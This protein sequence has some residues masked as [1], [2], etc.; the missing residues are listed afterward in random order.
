M[1]PN[2]V[3]LVL[4][5][6]LFVGTSDALACIGFIGA[7]N[8]VFDAKDKSSKEQELAKQIYDHMVKVDD[9]IP[10]LS[11][12]EKKWLESEMNAKDSRRSLRAL[13]SNEA[14]LK[15]AKEGVAV[16][17]FLSKKILDGNYKH[18]Q[19]EVESWANIAGTLLDNRI[20]EALFILHQREVIKLPE[21]AGVERL[22]QPSCALVARNI[23]YSI[24]I[25]YL[26]EE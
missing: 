7:A 12:V 15:Q 10:N 13:D 5:S 24:V 16:V 9:A 6:T 18:R 25:S 1:R 8:Q 21:L 4:L 14:H 3:S 19:A 2:I 20:S 23:M 22:W 17:V 26:R 11:P